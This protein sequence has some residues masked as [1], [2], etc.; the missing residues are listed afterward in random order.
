MAR[1]KT[2]L[3][4]HSSEDTRLALIRA[5]ERLFAER[6]IDAISL[7]EVSAEA[8]QGNN[9][10]VSYHFQSREGLIDAILERHSIPIHNRWDAQ[11]D[12]LERQNAVTLRLL[13]EMLTLPIV[14]KLD[15]P[16]GGWAY[17][18][19]AAQLSVN[20]RMPLVHRPVGMRPPVLRLIGSMMPFTRAP[21]E[22]LAYRFERISSTIYTSAVIFHRIAV[23]SGSAFPR[24]A[25]ESDLV[26]ALTL[27]IEMP[28]SPA[29]LQA[30][31]GAHG[32]VPPPP[33]PPPPPMPIP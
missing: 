5:A 9:S 33:P 29:T 2:G 22:L 4:A 31:A 6:G 27:A 14:G 21:F 17:L 1:S 8:G 19:I 30:L 16:D 7:R 24:A 23:E 26:D 18:S 13:V 28:S 12:L 3:G 10:A 15:D 11:L 25:F 20:P 32:I